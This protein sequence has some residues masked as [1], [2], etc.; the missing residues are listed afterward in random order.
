MKSSRFSVILVIL[1]LPL[2]ASARERKSVSPR[3]KEVHTVF[4]VGSGQMAAEARAKMP[5]FTCFA[6]AKTAEEADALVEI[7]A[8]RST[9]TA[10][11]NVPPQDASIEEPNGPLERGLPIPIRPET[12]RPVNRS[13]SRSRATLELAL[14]VKTRAGELLWERE[15]SSA[16]EQLLRDLRRD[17]CPKKK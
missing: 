15:G 17:A 8:R 13:S 3:L 10:L 4:V 1:G 7:A 12:G 14:R 9:Q 5:R 11:G 2:Q 6:L 16:L